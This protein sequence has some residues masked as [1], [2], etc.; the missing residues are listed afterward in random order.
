[1]KRSFLF[2]TP[3]LFVIGTLA[4][5]ACSSS[6]SDA[7]STACERYARSLETECTK[8][9]SD[10][11][12]SNRTSRGPAACKRVLTASGVTTTPA[13]LDKCSAA[14][15]AITTCDAIS[16]LPEPC[17]GKPGTRAD[18]AGCGSDLQCTSSYCKIGQTQVKTLDG[19]ISQR[20][21]CGTCTPTVAANAACNGGDARCVAGY[22]C[23]SGKCLK[24]VVSDVGGPCGN[25]TARCKDE[26]LCDNLTHTCAARK[27]VGVD[28]LGTFECEPPFACVANKCGTR[29]GEG[30]ACS[31]NE[32]ERKLRCDEGAGTCVKIDFAK[33][34]AACAKPTLCEP[35]GTVCP[36]SNTCPV[37]VGDGEACDASPT[38]ARLCN[39]YATCRDGK[40]APDD[41]NV[42]R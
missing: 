41:P 26:L 9:P 34:G 40:C 35:L 7:T 23:L 15:E 14:L 31:S 3:C 38:G 33:A 12:E 39:A 4:A 30:G 37:I 10:V 27:P 29:V 20:D 11:V 24:V 5:S 28:C 19:T 36:A 1:M 6:S 32:C 8:L 16:A 17:T 18:G 21:A 25:Q 22:E 2:F 13:D 42:C